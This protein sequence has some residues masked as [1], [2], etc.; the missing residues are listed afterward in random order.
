MNCPGSVT[1]LQK[2]ALEESDEADWTKEGLAAHEAAAHALEQELDAWELAGLTFHNLQMTAELCNPLQIYLDHCRSIDCGDERWIETALSSPVHPQFYGRLDF[3]AADAE[4]LHV[5]DLKFGAGVMVEIDHN[6]QTM[7]YAFL[8]IDELERATGKEMRADYPIRLT[9]VQPRGFHPAG[10]VRSFDTTVGEIKAWVHGVL[11]PAM[12][13]TEYEGTLRPG[14]WCRFCPAKL[15]CPALT[16]IFEAAIKADAKHLV[17]TSDEALG[18]GYP[19]L[20]AAKHY[21]KA[22]E[23]E[24]FA[25]RLRGRIIPNT[26]LVHKKA[27]RVWKDGAPGLAMARWGAKAMTEPQLKSPAELEK[28]PEAGDWVKEFS[29][30]PDTGLTL[31]LATDSRHEVTVVDP[32]DRFKDAVREQLTASVAQDSEW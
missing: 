27:N 4:R 5:I 12:L 14:D 8:K 10:P 13:A 26:K 9:I 19:L 20:E 6:V 32:K 21:I 22:Y 24:A 16:G 30:T 28:L 11:V 2:L 31:A 23:A 7:Y 15:V 18:A 17:D 1:L 3:S 29:Y 25:R